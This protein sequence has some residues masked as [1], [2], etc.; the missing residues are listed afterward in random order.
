MHYVWTQRP[1]EMQGT[2]LYSMK[3]LQ[4]RH[5][6][7]AKQAQ[8]KYD[9]RAQVA[10]QTLPSLN[11]EWSDLIFISPIDP[12]LLYTALIKSI[13]KPLHGVRHFFEIP[14]H[15]LS[16]QG[17]TPWRKD[18]GVR[19]NLSPLTAAMLPMHVAPTQISAWQEDAKAGR[20]PLLLGHSPHLLL[21]ARED[22]FLQTNDFSIKSLDLSQL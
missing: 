4:K 2:K 22:G 7:L 5:P 21:V 12:V 1:K 10:T 9:G 14:F 20:Q 17:F 3:G 15:A 8:Q 6:H 13:K 18:F 16:E 19:D 11:C